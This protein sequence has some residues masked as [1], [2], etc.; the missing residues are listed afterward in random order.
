[1]N[2]VLI[3]LIFILFQIIKEYNDIYICLNKKCS[4][5][6][7]YNPYKDNFLKEILKNKDGLV[8]NPKY[9]EDKKIINFIKN[10]NYKNIKSL[11]FKDFCNILNALHNNYDAIH[12][13]TFF[14]S[15]FIRFVKLNKKFEYYDNFNPL[16]VNYLN[17]YATFIEPD[18]DNIKSLFD[19]NFD[20]YE[21]IFHYKN[22][23]GIIKK[24]DFFDIKQIQS[25]T[26][27]LLNENNIINILYA[28]NIDNDFH[29]ISNQWFLTYLF[30]SFQNVYLSLVL[31]KMILTNTDNI[32]K[33][34]KFVKSATKEYINFVSNYNFTD[35][36]DDPELNSYYKFIKKNK[37]IEDK[38][39]NIKLFT[40]YNKTLQEI[41]LN[42]MSKENMLIIIVLILLLPIAFKIYNF[43]FNK[44][45]DFFINK[46][47]YFFKN[48]QIS[49]FFEILILLLIFSFIFLKFLK[50][51]KFKKW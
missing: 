24:V 34:I 41:L 32:I 26:F 35:I 27:I 46:L 6:E 37:T 9:K 25:N 2:L 19:N 49:Y 31:D 28:K 51:I 48:E 36:S 12:F 4:L 47:D 39:D 16:G 11:H 50:I 18:R 1:M 38:L 10:N 3:I 17:L 44:I 22:K 42:S 20:K 21:P 40:G 45:S 14:V 30:V 33:E 8:D 7:K 43:I 5:N 15:L 23:I 29:F 13:D